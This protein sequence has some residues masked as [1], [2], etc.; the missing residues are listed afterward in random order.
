MKRHMK[1]ISAPRTWALPRK[2]NK[3]VTRPYPGPHKKELGTS[4]EFFFKVM[5]N[6]V[7]TKREVNHLLQTQEVLLNGKRKKDRRTPVGFL[8][9]IAIPKAKEYYTITLN[10]DGFL[11]AQSITAKEAVQR[12]CKLVRKT[13]MKKKVQ[14]NFLDGTTL[15]VDDAK[16]Y[17]LGDTLVLSIPEHK[18]LEHIPANKGSKIIIYAGTNRGTQSTIKDIE[19]KQVIFEKDGASISTKKEYAI[20]I[21]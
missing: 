6:T 2:E 17:A 19:G 4:L 3:F 7:K 10:R 13:P 9:V 5:L 20:A 15:T 8:D 21:A 12:Y 11:D 18:L 14:L 1:R 16:K